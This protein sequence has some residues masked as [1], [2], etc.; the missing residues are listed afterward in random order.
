MY[1][2]ERNELEQKIEESNKTVSHYIVTMG[3]SMLVA[4]LT[5][6]VLTG[7]F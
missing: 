5:T 2:K 7:K 4:I 1:N 3:V 6:L